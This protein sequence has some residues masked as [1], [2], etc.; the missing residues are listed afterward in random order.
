MTEADRRKCPPLLG[1][2]FI[3]KEMDS[4]R[5]TVWKD[6]SGPIPLHTST[7]GFSLGKSRGEL[8]RD[9]MMGL[10]ETLGQKLS[11]G[12]GLYHCEVAKCTWKKGK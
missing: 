12:G 11:R 3:I 4:G 10:I 9:M 6:I 5:G 2:E 8:N 7:E 1:Q